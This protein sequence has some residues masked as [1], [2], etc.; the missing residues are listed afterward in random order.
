MRNLFLVSAASLALSACNAEPPPAPDAGNPLFVQEDPSQRIAY[1]DGFAFD[2]EAYVMRAAA[3]MMAVDADGNPTCQDMPGWTDFSGIFAG[4]K[5]IGGTV[6]LMNPGPPPPVATATSND[7]GQ[8]TMNGIPM[9]GF[10]FLFS[11]GPATPLTFDGDTLPEIPAPPNYLPTLTGRPVYTSYPVCYFQEA[12]F[13]GDNGIL[14]TVANALGKTPADLIDPA[15]Y[16]GVQIFMLW[17]PGFPL[18]R[19]PAMGVGVKS[20]TGHVFQID[21]APPGS[22]IPGQSDRGFFVSDQPDSPLGIA[23]I[24]HDLGGPEQATYTFEDPVVDDTQARP[25]VTDPMQIPI[26]SGVVSFS[27]MQ[28]SPTLPPG[29]DTGAGGD[30]PPYLCLPGGP[31]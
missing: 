12:A 17:Q 18:L 8:F 20:D 28:L 30:L 25:W 19:I 13:V 24:V 31:G 16:A 23:V 21:F 7:M 11:Q 4:S 3:C 15:Q 29:A 27:D 26:T 14:Q 5:L 9:D 22:G 6:A 10:Y 2:P 1:I